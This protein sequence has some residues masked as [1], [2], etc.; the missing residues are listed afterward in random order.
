MPVPTTGETQISSYF[1]HRVNQARTF[2][3]RGVPIR[4]SN[5]FNIQVL[6]Q[7]AQNA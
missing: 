7:P 3:A 4:T 5:G 2:R 1:A 6:D